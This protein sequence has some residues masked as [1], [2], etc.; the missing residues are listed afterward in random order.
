[1]KEIIVVYHK[2]NYFL[3]IHNFIIVTL[4]KLITEF[5][6]SLVQYV[7]TIL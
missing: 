4:T 5:I 1:M 7:L 6:H 3:I 2:N